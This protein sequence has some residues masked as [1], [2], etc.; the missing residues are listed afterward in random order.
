M[1][2]NPIQAKIR[3]ILEHFSE[4]VPNGRTLLDDCAREAGDAW[5]QHKITTLPL[6][7]TM[8]LVTYLKLCDI[9]AWE[10]SLAYAVDSLPIEVPIEPDLATW[11]TMSTYDNADDLPVDALA[12][13]PMPSCYLAV[14]NLFGPI[15]NGIFVVPDR[16]DGLIIIGADCGQAILPMIV[17][18]DEL[19]IFEYP[20]TFESL[21]ACTDTPVSDDLTEQILALVLALGQRMANASP[22]PNSAAVLAQATDNALWS[23]LLGR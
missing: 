3:Y 10:L 23:Q 22:T 20:P 21:L 18:L 12:T 17:H 4:Q 5:P 16:T 13:W 14:P 8:D 7:T 2:P 1:E 9:S 11:L 15:I 6:A 19:C